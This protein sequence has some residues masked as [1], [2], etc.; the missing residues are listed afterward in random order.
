MSAR[1]AIKRASLPR[2]VTGTPLALRGRLFV[3]V[4][5]LLAVFGTAISMIPG[6][7]NPFGPAKAFVLMCAI[8]AIAAGVALSPELALGL[9]RR[10]R[11]TRGVWAAVALLG[12]AVLATVMSIAPEQS[13]VGHYPE[14]QG[15]VLLLAG[16]L[17]GFGA[18]LH[19][20]PSGGREASRVGV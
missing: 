12:V 8:T 20:L 17:V 7:Y 2:N 15:L 10:A 1:P 14:Y 18:F 19:L 5:V 11:S 9:A 13:L 3:L 4:G 16:A 6:G